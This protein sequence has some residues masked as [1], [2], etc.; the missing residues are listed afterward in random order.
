M[1][2]MK[3]DETIN[4]RI[5]IKCDAIDFFA[6]TVDSSHDKWKKQILIEMYDKITLQ[7]GCSSM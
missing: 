5:D 2:M 1:I 6:K 7:V 3:R 4:Y